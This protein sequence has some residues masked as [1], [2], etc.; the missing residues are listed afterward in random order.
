MNALLLID[1][2]NDFLPGGALAAPRG[3]AILPTVQKLVT[4]PFDLV[5]ASRDRHPKDHMSFAST[6]GKKVHE[7]IEVDGD[8][9]VLWPDHCIPGTEGAELHPSL[10]KIKIDYFADKGT[11]SHLDSYS[12]F[13]D[14]KGNVAT[15]LYDYLKEK[16]VTTLYCVGLV[17]EYCVKETVLDALQLGFRVF[18]VQEGISP[19]DLND[20]IQA[21]EELRAAGA[22]VISINDLRLE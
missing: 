20:G 4:L 17:T 16:G 8:E 9:Q 19:I 22:E 12:A 6:H 21:I 15:G 2:Q 13:F 11:E 10:Q 14:R 3:D 18:V 1:I 5:I 7:R